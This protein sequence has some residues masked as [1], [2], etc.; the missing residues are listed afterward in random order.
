M[1][2]LTPNFVHFFVQFGNF[3]M[4]L[5]HQSAVSLVSNKPPFRC[6]GIRDRKPI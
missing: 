2:V 6:F 5:C 1:L 4:N 3:I